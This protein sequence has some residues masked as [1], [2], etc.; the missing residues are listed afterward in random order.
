MANELKHKDAGTS[1]TRTEDNATDRHYFDSQAAGDILYATDTVANSGVLARLG[2]GST[3]KVLTVIGG[4][5]T[6]QSTLSGL[7]LTAPTL[8]SPTFTWTRVRT[9]LATN[10][11]I[12]PTATN[13]KVALNAETAD[14]LGEFV[15]S[16]ESGTTDGDGTGT[17]KLIDAGQNFVTTVAVGDAI[18][19]NTD[20]TWTA[21]TAVDDNENLSVTAGEGLNTAKAYTIYRSR[22]TATV[23]GAF[24]VLAGIGYYPTVAD[25]YYDLLIYKNGSALQNTRLHS[26]G[27]AINSVILFGGD[28]IPMAINDYLELWTYHNAAVAQ[29]TTA[30]ASRT[31]FSIAKIA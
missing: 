6:W 13:R 23:A 18:R 10:D 1:L 16:Q 3:N 21:V 2:I 14:T 20:G 22:F 17:D 15:T 5:P 28:I 12:V 7:T 30:H 27:A 11:Q 26:S 25:K 29:N 24:V 4:V 31:F 8:T 9:N 19:N